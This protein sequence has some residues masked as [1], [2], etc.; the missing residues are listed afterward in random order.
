MSQIRLKEF[1]DG[2]VALFKLRS[3][4]KHSQLCRGCSWESISSEK[5]IILFT[6]TTDCKAQKLTIKVA[7]DYFLSLTKVIR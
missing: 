7:Y 4:W 2:H 6:V 5:A 1:C 3:K